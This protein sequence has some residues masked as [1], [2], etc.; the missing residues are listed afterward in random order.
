M[1]N[2]EF[3]RME[4]YMLTCYNRTRTQKR[5]SVTLWVVKNAGIC[6]GK[7][8]KNIGYCYAIRIGGATYVRE[9]RYSDHCR[10]FQ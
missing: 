2:C 8:Y 5:K 6:S 9:T 3:L 10:N 7:E 4:R 1:E